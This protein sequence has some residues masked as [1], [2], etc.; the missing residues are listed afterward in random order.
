[1]RKHVFGVKS[2]PLPPTTRGGQ[3]LT[4]RRTRRG[5]TTGACRS[6]QRQSSAHPLPFCSVSDV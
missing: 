2:Y 3:D 5:W 1:M 4:Q 6:A